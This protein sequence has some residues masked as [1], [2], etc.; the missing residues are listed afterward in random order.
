MLPGEQRLP[1]AILIPDGTAVNRLFA[2]LCQQADKKVLHDHAYMLQEIQLQWFSML[3]SALQCPRCGGNK[4]IRKGW[5]ERR[6]KSSRGTISLVV[7][8][9]R[10][11]ACG[12][13]FRPLNEIIGLPFTMRFTDELVQKSVK[14]GLQLSFRKSAVIIKKLTN[15]T[16]SAEGLRRKIARL[17]ESLCLPNMVAGQ[18]VLVD[19]TKVKAG[20]KQRGA[21]VHLAITAEK[22]PK[23]MGR[24][25]IKKNHFTCTLA[26]SIV[27]TTR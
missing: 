27:F 23:Q 4:L 9:A 20:K 15:E 14:L 10:C 5:R 26:V 12:R 25:S 1:K 6:L 22:G 2:Y 24:S 7:L 19:S 17:A 3:R 13:T 18:T 11:K 21:S 16:I 8:Q